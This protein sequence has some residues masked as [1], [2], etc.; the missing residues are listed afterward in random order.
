MTT[1]VLAAVCL[2]LLAST[3]RAQEAAATPDAEVKEILELSGQK[4][5]LEQLA[6]Q[7]QGQTAQT[8]KG[9]SAKEQKRLQATMKQAFKIE[10]LYQTVFEHYRAKYDAKRATALLEWLRSPLGRKIIS[11]EVKA[12]ATKSPKARENYLKQ[13]KAKPLPATREALIERVR[14]AS[15]S[16]EL[17]RRAVRAMA[18]STM[19]ASTASLPADKRASAERALD[20][21]LSSMDEKI[22]DAVHAS[23]LYT[24]RELP[25]EDLRAYIQFLESDAGK[26]HVQTG[27]DADIKAIEQA[28]TKVG[29]DIRQIL[30]EKN[31][32]KR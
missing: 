11:H 6:A 17:T 28:G 29:Q 20:Q 22:R 21:L 24:Y 16:L 12:L 18:R 32:G 13:L 4:K 5:L 27:M 25:D 14:E 10:A 26:W 3:A 15:R 23:M 19:D 30:E 1:R 2:C 7:S 8:R 9:L 31:K